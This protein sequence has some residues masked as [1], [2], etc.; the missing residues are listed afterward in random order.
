[1]KFPRTRRWWHWLIP[2]IRRCEMCYWPFG[3]RYRD[4][5]TVYYWS[6]IGQQRNR[7][8]KLCRRCAAAHR[9]H[10]D[11]VWAEVNR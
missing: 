2:A 9:E 8:V 1:M 5:R 6:G 3:V 4:S 7:P 11:S 10:W